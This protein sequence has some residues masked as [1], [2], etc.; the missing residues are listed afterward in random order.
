MDIY[1]RPELDEQVR[2]SV[3]LLRRHLNAP[4]EAQSDLITGVLSALGRSALGGK[5]LRSRLVHISAGRVEGAQRAA[6]VTFGACVDLLHAAFLIHDDIIDRDELRRGESTVHAGIAA[7]TGDTH[8]GTSAAILAGDFAI[9]EAIRLIVSAGM[10]P[11]LALAAIDR[12]TQSSRISVLGELLDVEHTLI[13]PP[14]PERV[15]I[16][17]NLKT[18]DYTFASPLHL[19]AL[20]AG[21]D[22]ASTVSLALELGAAFQ[23]A[24]DIAGAISD[25]AG[26]RATLATFQSLEDA[27]TEGRAHLDRAITLVDDGEFPDDVATDLRGVAGWIDGLLTGGER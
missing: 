14:A 25:V 2:K 27:S 17:N 11:A 19:G 5:H 4:V 7:L 23:A 20:A 9:T 22:P 13:R 16:A 10:D 15:R 12:L 3:G 8:V 24:N 18:S 1:S 6:A 21:R 26:E